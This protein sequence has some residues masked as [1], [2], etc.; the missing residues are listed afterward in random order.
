MVLM[1]ILGAGRTAAQE[2][3]WGDIPR[4]LAVGN[5]SPVV[6]VFGIPKARGAA[7]TGEGEWQWDATLDLTSHFQVTNGAGESIILDGETARAALQARYGLNESWTLGLE[8][9]WVHHGGGFLD[10]FIIDWHDFWG[11]PQR[12]RDRDER[13]KIDFRYVRGGNARINID[14]AAEGPGDVIVSAQRRL[15]RDKDSTGLLHTQLKLPTGDPDKLTGS[16]AVD[17]GAGVELVRRWRQRWHSSFRAGAAYLG[18]GDV[19]PDLQRHWVGY[20]GFDVIWRPIRA[21]AFRVQF[22]AHTAP[23]HDSGLE[24]LSDWSGMLTTGGTW[25][26]TRDTALDLAVVEN[27]PNFDTVSDVSFQVRLRTNLGAAR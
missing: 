24:E 13:D 9:P 7:V 5:Q 11:F 8:L 27:V 17:A 6:G 23:Y 2:D 1:L 22:D 25:H 4:P 15:W 10:S 12:G 18:E 14:S 16:G 26:V 20:G 19:L 3:A 21:L